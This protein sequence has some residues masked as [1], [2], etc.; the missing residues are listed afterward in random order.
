MMGN[1]KQPRSSK[2]R[3]GAPSTLALAAVLALSVVTTKSAQAQTFTVL[4]SF[5]GSPGPG[6]PYPSLLQDTAGNLYGT[7][8]MGGTSDAGTVFEVSKSGQDTVLHN[9]TGDPD[10]ANPYASLI[11]D[12]AGNLYGTTAAGGTANA[13]TVF[14][15]SKAGTETVLYSFAG[16]TTDGCNPYGGLIRDTA[17]NLYGTTSGCG[18]SSYGTVFELSKAG[19]E[20]VLHSFAYSDG[21]DPYL[22]S[23]LMDAKGNLYGITSKGGA[24]YG[25]VYKLS[26]NGTFT[27]LH[28]FTGGTTD[29]CYASGT[30]WMDTK[31]NLYG[32]AEECGSS[33]LGI[34][35]KLSKKGRE[36]VLHHFAGGKSDG[37]NPY[38][39][40]VMDAAKNLYGTTYA[41]GASNLGMV[42][43]LNAKGTPTVLHSFAGSDGENPYGGLIRDAKGGFYGTTFTG[44]SGGAGT[45]WKL[46][47]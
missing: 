1:T 22:T 10:G 12:T 11:R 17:D 18:A 42:Y 25:T 9:F 24:G 37:A 13:G 40:V 41:G 8:Y 5:A 7:T 15:L 21:A 39:G 27:L 28:S 16:G 29:G 34:V 3:L 46:K 26:K 4:W 20:T 30:P 43:E 47:Q 38:A 14:K 32:T 23:L 6:N 31:G 2:L 36:T 45:V 44:G 19:K 35:W 33:N